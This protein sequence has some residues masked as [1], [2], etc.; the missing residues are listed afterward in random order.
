[1]TETPEV[2]RGTV[3]ADIGQ[4]HIG[5]WLEE[6]TH[7]KAVQGNLYGFVEPDG[8]TFFTR[9]HKAFD[10]KPHP[11]LNPALDNLRAAIFDNLQKRVDEAIAG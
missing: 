3:S 8:K 7:V 2:I 6:G 11:I 5:L 1:V 9:G 10:V 4:K